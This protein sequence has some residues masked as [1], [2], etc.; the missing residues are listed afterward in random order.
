MTVY[1][2]GK[3]VETVK[4]GESSNLELLR[5]APRGLY[6][7]IDQFRHFIRENQL[8]DKAYPATLSGSQIEYL[9]ALWRVFDDFLVDRPLRKSANKVTK[10]LRLSIETFERTLTQKEVWPHGQFLPKPLRRASKKLITSGL[11]FVA[12]FRF[13]DG[14]IQKIPNRPTDWRIKRR[15]AVQ[16][17]RHQAKHGPGS[18]PKF[19]ALMK[20]LNKYKDKA[21]AKF[22]LSARHYWNYK[23][24]WNNGTYWHYFPT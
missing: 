13:Y 4:R 21:K 16:I 14:L 22:Q 10:K 1:R 8:Y 9:S 17:V 15:V 20:R 7:L 19:P 23:K 5:I 12:S 3:K 6:F 2:T 18:F 24:H 11:R